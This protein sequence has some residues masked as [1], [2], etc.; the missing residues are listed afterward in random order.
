MVFLC[1]RKRTRSFHPWKLLALQRRR[2]RLQIIEF[3]NNCWVKATFKFNKSVCTMFSLSPLFPNRGIRWSCTGFLRRFRDIFCITFELLFHDRFTAKD[4]G[5]EFHLCG[6]PES[7][8]NHSEIEKY[9]DFDQ[10]YAGITSYRCIDIKNIKK[11]CP[12]YVSLACK[13]ATRDM[14]IAGLCRFH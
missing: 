7:K 13:V 11:L 12:V 4:S 10:F 5:K 3:Q 1:W 8:T 14:T 2:Q 9:G 6:M